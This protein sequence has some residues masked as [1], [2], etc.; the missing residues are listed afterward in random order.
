MFAGEINANISGTDDTGK[1]VRQLIQLEATKEN[2]GS[3]DIRGVIKCRFAETFPQV[4]EGGYF[5]RAQG[6]LRASVLIGRGFARNVGWTSEIA[7]RN[8]EGLKGQIIINAENV[9]NVVWTS[10]VKVGPGGATVINGGDTSFSPPYAYP[11]TAAS[12]GGG[13]ITVV[14]YHLHGADCAP[15]QGEEVDPLFSGKKICMRY[16]GP[17]EWSP[18]N[19]NPYK[20]ERRMYGSGNAWMEQDCFTFEPD[21][22]DDTVV[23]VVNDTK[24]QRGF[25]Y[26]VSL[27]YFNNNGN[28]EPVLRCAGLPNGTDIPVSEN[29]SSLLF[30][31]CNDAAL[32]DADDNGCVNFADITSV[33]ANY[34]SGSACCMTYGDADRD[35]DVDFADV[36]QVLAMFEQAYCGS[37][38]SG[39]ASGSGGDGFTAMGLDAEVA[40]ASSPAETISNALASMG[41]ASIEDFVTTIFAMDEASREAEI[42][43]LGQLLGGE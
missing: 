9:G 15:Y 10:D 42:R 34:C 3:G 19:G 33:L 5:I 23:W 31:V 37:C 20:V 41:Y 8:V 17:V 26:R 43:R 29:A 28:T 7:A 22:D 16:Y 4:D 27:N 21:L 11:N 12:L 30:S 1:F 40:A 32:G 2:G 38:S 18:A 35:G 25:E 6:D 14:R 36:S 24:F 39:F 13:S